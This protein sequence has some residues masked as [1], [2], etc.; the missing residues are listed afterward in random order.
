MGGDSYNQSQEARSKQATGG[1]RATSNKQQ[2][3]SN[4]QQVTSNEQ[5]ATS[6]KQRA[7]SNEQQTTFFISRPAIFRAAYR[8]FIGNYFSE[9]ACFR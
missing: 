4:K 3:T 9:A 6:N 8:L 7:T 2:V 5:R 1:K